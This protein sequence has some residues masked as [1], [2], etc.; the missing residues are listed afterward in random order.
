M[1]TRTVE[2][3]DPVDTRSA[4]AP[5]AATRGKLTIA[6]KAI[7]KIAGQVAS[8]IPGVSG[9][10]GG[11]LG[12]GS[13]P[14]ETARPRAKVELH[15]LIASIHL[16][17][18]IRYPAPLRSTTNALRQRVRDE[19]SARCGVDVRQVDIDI[20]ELISESQSAGRR[21]LL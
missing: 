21:E 15:G 18:G 7:E 2:T 3:E 17:V 11:F 20:N 14:E 19:V 5:D 16:S 4:E 8:E 1:A 6:E 10:A 12:I 13:H 9:S